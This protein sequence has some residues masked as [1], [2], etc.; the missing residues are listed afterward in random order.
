VEAGV[1]YIRMRRRLLSALGAFTVALMVAGCASSRSVLYSGVTFGLTGKRTVVTDAAAV[2]DAK[3]IRRHWLG[4]TGRHS[5]QRFPNL[6]KAEFSRRLAAAAARYHFTVKTAQFRHAGQVTPLV[7]LRTD[8]YVA[9][10]RAIPSIEQSLDPHKRAREDWSG[11]TFRAFYLEAQDERGVPF[12]VVE[13]VIGR[14]SAAGGQW[15]RSDALFPF[16]HG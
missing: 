12:V 2:R 11:W 9:L 8:R 14:G 13:N 7:V 4:E 1:V 16:L 5:S 3:G 15:A 6:P 10:A